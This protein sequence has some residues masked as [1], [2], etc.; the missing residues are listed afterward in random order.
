[1]DHYSYKKTLISVNKD[2]KTFTIPDTVT[3]IGSN[4]FEKCTQLKSIIIPDNVI[5]IGYGAFTH[6]DSL[7]EITISKNVTSIYPSTFIFCENLRYI[8]MPS[9]KDIKQGSLYD[10]NNL[11][12]IVSQL[13]TDQI[14]KA[15][16][17][18]IDNDYTSGESAYI[19]YKQRNREYKLSQLI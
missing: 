8:N 11:I 2:V 3:V 13:S 15:F 19:Q 18:I 12:N 17:V 1:M 5:E 4:A 14:I 9:V 16:N 10:C 6:C 7:S